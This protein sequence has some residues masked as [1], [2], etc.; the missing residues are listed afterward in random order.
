MQSEIRSN[1]LRDQLKDRS[2]IFR[3]YLEV[4]KDC[5]VRDAGGHDR[6]HDDDHGDGFNDH[7]LRAYEMIL[8]LPKYCL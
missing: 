2:Q 8:V 7:D 1:L 5:H 6:D 4:M 3:L